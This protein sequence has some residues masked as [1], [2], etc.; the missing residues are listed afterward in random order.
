MQ[1][2]PIIPNHHKSQRGVALIMVLGMVA[3]IAAWASTA[4]YEDMVSIRRIA[5]I[6]DEVRA[7]MA[8][9]SAYAL[10]KLYLV[11]DGKAD[12]GYDSLEDD[13]AMDLPPLP[14]DEGLISA[15][16]E[17]SN[18]YY[19]LNDLVDS[20]GNIQPLHFNQLQ[21]L[22]L[23][24][25]L[26]SQLVNALADWMD[27]DS[28]PY[29]ATGAEDSAYYD[30]DYKIKNARLDNWNELKLILGF[31]AEIIERLKVVATVRPS[32]S[33]GKSK[34][35]INT[36]EPFVLMALFPEMQQ[37]D[38]ES[39]LE[40][41]PYDDTSGINNQTWKT[42]GDVSRLKVG[43]DAFMLRTH[44]MF[45]RANVREEFL[46]SRNGQSVTL[47]SRERLGWQF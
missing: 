41:R 10:V 18:R 6:Q 40:N 16:I 44:A 45:G 38:E 7:T 3:I 11:E 17:D 39:F 43:S 30:K 46:L 14:I 19:N 37:L 23:L 25:E 8:N 42:D 34:I 27:K 26:D 1:A 31:D 12:A 20:A 32:P 5:N 21:R 2:K 36:A 28:A 15:T 47:L 29:G 4:T 13:W 22:F 33:D 24:L 35:N 9:E